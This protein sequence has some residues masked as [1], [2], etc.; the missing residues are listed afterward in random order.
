MGALEKVCGTIYP[1]D[2][3][4]IWFNLRQEPT[5]YVNGNPICARPANKIGEYAELG[6]ITRD[7]IKAQETA[8]LGE[9][10][11]LSTLARV[12]FSGRETF[13]PQL[14]P[15]LKALQ[16]RTSRL[17]WDRS[18][19]TSTRPPTSCSPTCPRLITRKEP[20]IGSPPRP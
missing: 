7:I 15:I 9:C 3:P 17:T 10:E 2:G 20:S 6:A 1:K 5:V 8:F 11:S 18:S 12:T 14:C 16:P 19:T 13:P 4:I